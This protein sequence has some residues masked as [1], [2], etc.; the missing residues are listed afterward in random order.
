MEAGPDGWNDRKSELA[1]VSGPV[2]H[3]PRFGCCAI[4]IDSRS[5]AR[6]AVRLPLPMVAALGAKF[7][8]RLECRRA[9]GWPKRHEAVR[10][11][12][13]RRQGCWRDRRSDLAAVSVAMPY[14][15]ELHRLVL[16]R[17]R[18]RAGFRPSARACLP[19]R[20]PF[21]MVAI[22]EFGFGTGVKRWRAFCPAGWPIYD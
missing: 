19:V 2:P 10:E 20:L 13:E 9:L 17:F 18:S 16:G 14:T 22:I 7:R 21:P 6:P 15:P 11:P 3:A 4:H 5:R 12:M 8:G 1:A